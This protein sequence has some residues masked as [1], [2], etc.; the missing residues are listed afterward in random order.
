MPKSKATADSASLKRVQDAFEEFGRDDPM[1][2]A[3]SRSELQGNRWDATA[4]FETGN[5][6]IGEV[7]AY[8][9][10]LNLQARRGR[11]L[12][13]GCAVGRL[14]QALADRFAEVVGVDIASSMVEKARGYNRHGERVRYLVNTAP[15][16]RV[17]ETG[18]FDFVYSNKVLQHI[19]PEHQITYIREF[20]RVLAPG[21]IA[22]FQ[23]RNGPRIAPG[24]L[25]ALLYTLNRKHFRWFSR[26]IRGRKPY[27]HQMHYIAGSQIEEAIAEMGGRIVDVVDLSRGKPNKSLR[28]CVERKG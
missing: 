8:V 13:F 3:L 12:D 14:S 21:G 7:L 23:T 24:T 26:R 1:Y 20:M 16:L 6:E 28:Y 17:L 5:T 2:A 9:R 10:A 11:A 15:D 18:S 4:F 25:R 27:G 22:V 19:P